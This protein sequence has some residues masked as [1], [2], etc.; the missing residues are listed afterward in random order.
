MAVAF[1]SSGF[2]LWRLSV[3]HAGLTKDGGFLKQR[4]FFV[5][6]FYSPCLPYE[7]RS[8]CRLMN[9]LGF[10]MRWLFLRRLSI[11]HAGLTNGG[12]FLMRQLY[13]GFLFLP[14]A[15]L[16][17]GGGFRA[18]VYSTESDSE[19]SITSIRNSLQKKKLFPSP[20]LEPLKSTYMQHARQR[21]RP[22][23]LFATERRHAIS[24]Y[25]QQRR[26]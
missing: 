17:N 8:P 21:L 5:A 9:G 19:G 3:L 6:A 12:G 15:G 4:R 25:I 16:T 22:L 2:F 26:R 11:P 10:H 7:W 1:S 20:G 18:P 14:H 13:G 24:A 23:R